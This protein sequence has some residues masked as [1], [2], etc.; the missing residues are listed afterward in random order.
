VAP[1]GKKSEQLPL[2]RVDGQWR[3]D[4]VAYLKEVKPKLAKAAVGKFHNLLILY[5][6]VTGSLPTTEQGL[7]VLVVDPNEFPP[8]N[9]RRPRLKRIE[10]DPWGSPYR[11]E[12]PAKRNKSEKFDVFSVGPDK[13][14][15]T[16]DDIGTWQ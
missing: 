7:N 5:N 14:P 15:Y 10:L 13:E 4:V 9:D 16:D 1:G 2:V 11:Y 6:T 12:I 3:V 8:P